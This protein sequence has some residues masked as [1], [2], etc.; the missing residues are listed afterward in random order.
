MR[1]SAELV[2]HMRQ[3]GMICN[4]SFEN[5]VDTLHEFLTMSYKRL[6]L[7]KALS[8]EYTDAL[9][10]FS[11]RDFKRVFAT[12]PLALWKGCNEGKKLSRKETK[13]VWNH[14][15]SEIEKRMKKP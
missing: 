6:D 8:Q 9:L 2:M 3:F 12:M 4:L 1:K 5:E 10:N 15:K 13:L 11:M 14:L 7:V